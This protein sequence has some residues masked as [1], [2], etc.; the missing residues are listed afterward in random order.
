MSGNEI[1][2]GNKA[3]AKLKQFTPQVK[4]ALLSS[5]GQHGMSALS[6]VDIFADIVD[7]LAPPDTGA[8]PIETAIRV[9]RNERMTTITIG[10]REVAGQPFHTALR[11]W[12]VKSTNLMSKETSHPRGT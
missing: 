12:C 8:M 5:G 2:T 1:T 11:S 6:G 7:T 3:P 4:D 9:A 10:R